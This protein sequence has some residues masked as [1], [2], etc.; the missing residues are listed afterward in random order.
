MC[1][2]FGWGRVN[3]LHSSWSGALLWVCAANSVGNTGMFLL[4]LSSAHRVRAFS[5]PHTAP[6][7][8]GQGVHKKLGG[9]TARTAETS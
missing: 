7:V 6:S 5:A 4:L 3:F 8:R 9:D 1:A 2:G